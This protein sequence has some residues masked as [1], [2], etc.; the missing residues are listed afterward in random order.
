[1]YVRSVC[2][3]N[4]AG[5]TE[6][7]VR[8]CAGDLQSFSVVEGEGFAELARKLTGIGEKYGN[9]PVKDILPSSRTVSCNV[10]ELV[11]R[12]MY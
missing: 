9:I 8:F 2:A 4:K 11:T 1:M 3:S 12:E 7:V 10:Q 6:S 5:A